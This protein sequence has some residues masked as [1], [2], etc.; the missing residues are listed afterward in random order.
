[1]NFVDYVQALLALCIWREAAIDGEPG[2]S[3]VAHVILNRANDHD[4]PNSFA[5][6]ICQ[7]NQFSAMTF[8]GD[9]MTIRFPSKEDGAFST[10]LQIASK[11]YGLESSDPTGGATFYRNPKTAT[12]AWFQKNVAENPGYVLSKTIGH[13]DFFARIRNG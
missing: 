7:K 10:A 3:A 2:M 11:V 5:G 13:H 6:V 9:P 8:L 4:F 1:M 12:S